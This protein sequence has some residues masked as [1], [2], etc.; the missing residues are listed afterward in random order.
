[1]PHSAAAA[2]LTAPDASEEGMNTDTGSSVNAGAASS[3]IGWIGVC[4]WL[5]GLF[6]LCDYAFRNFMTKTGDVLEYAELASLIIFLMAL[7]AFYLIS[8]AVTGMIWRRLPRAKGLLIAFTVVCVVHATILLTTPDKTKYTLPKGQKANVSVHVQENGARIVNLESEGNLR[9]EHDVG[10]IA[11]ASAKNTHTPADLYPGVAACVVTKQFRAGAYL[12]ALA[13][14]YGTY[15]TLRVA[16]KSAH[17]AVLV[18]QMQARQRTPEADRVL[19]SQELRR[20]SQDTGEV[21]EMCRQIRQLGPP[22]YHPDYM[23]QHGMGAFT[24]GNGDNGIVPGFDEKTGWEKS[25]TTFLHCPP[26]LPLND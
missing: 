23:I 17:Q 13:G 24:G 4:L 2:D 14:V 3:R 11:I 5:L 21:A 8:A 1:M 9:S 22:S 6:V 26:L 19:F 12:E 25:L 16:D 20:A 15:D 18:L 7:A 10:C